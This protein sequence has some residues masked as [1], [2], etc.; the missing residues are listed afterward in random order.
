MVVESG[1]F[2]GEHI[3]NSI[4]L[5]TVRHWRCLLV[6]ANPRTQPLLLQKHR[7]CHVLLGGLSISDGPGSF[8][9][10]EAGPSSGTFGMFKKFPQGRRRSS[11]TSTEWVNPEAGNHT[12]YNVSTYP[13]RAIMNALGTNV[14]D[15][16]SLDTE[17][18][19]ADIIEHTDFSKLEVGVL[20]VE[21][22]AV[23]AYQSRVLDL[24][25]AR[26]FKRVK[27]D[28]ADDF[29]ASPL[30][31]KKRGIPFGPF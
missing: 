1:A 17:G 7:K 27:S 24:M 13:L 28:P 2:D 21:H 19:E 18:T 10:M 31:F 15:Y 11:K 26:G 6:E 25:L 12:F 9:L 4:F 5:E 29:Y 8:Q 3:S 30:Y 23:L 22:N 14:I 16:W 20:T